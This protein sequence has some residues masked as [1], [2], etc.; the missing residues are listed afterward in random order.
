MQ[1][2]GNTSAIEDDPIGENLLHHRATGHG[3]LEE[4]D[5]LDAGTVGNDGVRKTFISGGYGAAQPQVELGFRGLLRAGQRGFPG[6]RG[7]AEQMGIGNGGISRGVG[8]AAGVVRR[9]AA[10][11]RRSPVRRITGGNQHPDQARRVVTHGDDQRQGNPEGH[12]LR[13][14]GGQRLRALSIPLLYQLGQ[15][16][17]VTTRSRRPTGAA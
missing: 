3:I 2:F 7:H 11:S 15:F 14:P 5:L 6:C 8:P 1:C 12:D 9:N 13:G 17:W 10:E 4:V 16:Q